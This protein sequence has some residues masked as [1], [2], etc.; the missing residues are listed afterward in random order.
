M[1]N[2]K[3]RK[4][5][6]LNIHALKD[7]SNCIPDKQY[8]KY[9]SQ[10]LNYDNNYINM[11]QIWDL[12]NNYIKNYNSVWYKCGYKDDK[13]INENDIKYYITILKVHCSEFIL[14]GFEFSLPE[15]LYDSNGQINSIEKLSLLSY[16][17][18]WN[19]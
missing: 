12:I 16:N 18:D 7:C 10:I 13:I 17:G 15:N 11:F 8:E 9:L 2:L 1:I 5:F 3:I 4:F 6:A 19:I 14:I